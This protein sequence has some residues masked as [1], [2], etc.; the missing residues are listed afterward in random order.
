MTL[1]RLL[2]ALDYLHTEANVIHTDLKTDNV[3]LSLEETTM[4]ADFADKEIRHPILRKSID[5]TRTI[6]QSRQ[7]RRPLRGEARIGKTHNSGPFTWDLFEGR[8]LFGNIFDDE[9]NY[10]PFK[11]L[12]SMVALI[13]PP[14]PD[15]IQRSETMGQCFDRNGIWTAHEDAV[16]PWDS[17]ESLEMR[18]SDCEKES[19]LRFL[20]SMLKWLP[21]ERMTARQLLDDPWLL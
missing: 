20:R 18:L 6:Y 5:G 11:H 21:E 17:L 12:A 3:M 7:F 16:M 19:F 14:L 1:K 2:L 10:D 8:H 15:F 9:G 4:L 13:G